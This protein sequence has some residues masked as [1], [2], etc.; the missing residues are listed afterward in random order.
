[1]YKI[2]EIR[3]KII[4][5]DAL[6]ESKK[7]PNESVDC[8]ITSPPYWGLRD[9]GVEGQIGLEPTLDLC[10]DHLLQI[11]AEF[12][13]VLKKTGVMFWNHGDSYSAKS[14]HASKSKSTYYNGISKT[15]GKDSGR[16]VRSEQGRFTD[17]IPQKCLALQNYRLIL[18]MIDEQG[19]I[20]RNIVI[21][22]K[23]N[24]MPSSVKDKFTNAY[25]PVF[26]LV[27]N[28]KPV[29][30]Y[31]IKTGLIQSKK[32]LSIH[33]KEG[34]DW[35]WKPCPAC[36]IRVRDTLSEEDIISGMLEQNFIVRM[37]LIKEYTT[38]KTKIPEES[39]EKFGGPRARYYRKCTRKNCVNGFVK[40]SNWRSLD[41]W[42]DLDAVRVPH[43]SNKTPKKSKDW[44]KYAIKNENSTLGFNLYNPL[45]KN[46]GDVWTIPTQPFPEAHF[47][48][49][50]E[51]LIIPMIKAGCPQWICKKCGKARV[52]IVE[53]KYKGASQ[54]G[55]DKSKYKGQRRIQG[56]IKTDGYKG[57]TIGW[58][59]CN[60]QAGFEPG[61]V[62]DPFM[63]SG[64]T[65]V[66][67]KKL[68]RDF[69]GIEISEKYCEMAKKRINSIPKPLL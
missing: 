43:N 69:I 49:Y 65:G 25:E 3:N 56:N 19:W 54:F 44:N 47:A 62:L 26:M 64:T 2:E 66:V 35:D 50:P 29:Y 67:A 41:Y 32:P 24:H 52:R 13:R 20:L 18:R 22:H 23:P 53:Q 36:N 39:A 40:K 7:I 12:K 11:T 16:S 68:G 27:K 63:G 33:G 9:Y 10:I 21:W 5:G 42:F 14:T 59:S 60:C 61:I 4:C 48:V 15:Y 46:P 45:G 38:H 57:K 6:S 51:K 30:Y 28:N 8:I 1:M 17:N 31:N 58:T 55:G 34:V 37:S